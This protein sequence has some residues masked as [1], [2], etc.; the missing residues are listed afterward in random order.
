MAF[1]CLPS[2]PERDDAVCVLPYP[3]TVARCGLWDRRGRGGVACADGGCCARCVLSLFSRPTRGSTQSAASPPF[4]SSSGPER[5]PSPVRSHSPS[6]S[7]SSAAIASLPTPASSLPEIA[8]LAPSIILALPVSLFTVSGTLSF[9]R[10]C[11]GSRPSLRSASLP[12][13]AT[14]RPG[15]SSARG[16]SQAFSWGRSRRCRSSTLRRCVGERARRVPAGCAWAVPVCALLRRAEGLSKGCGRPW[17]EHL[18]R[19]VVPPNADDVPGECEQQ[20]ND[21]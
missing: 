4:P 7:Y 21:S 20:H 14:A 3:I 1:R 8:T 2:L 10:G 17:R 15:P 16:P 13:P 19:P 9:S 6:S 11:P 18:P 5:A 12:R